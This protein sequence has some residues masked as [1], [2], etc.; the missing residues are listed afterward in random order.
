MSEVWIAPVSGSLLD[1]DLCSAVQYYP[2]L[3]RSSDP[4]R[5]RQRQRSQATGRFQ[6]SRQD[7]G[8]EKTCYRW[9]TM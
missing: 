4:H 6:C 2:L 9:K 3:H 1:L 8:D 7:R 5:R